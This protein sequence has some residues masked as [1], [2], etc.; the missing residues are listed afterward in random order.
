MGAQ[1]TPQARKTQRCEKV[2]SG[3]FPVQCPFFFFL[4]LFAK[5]ELSGPA[6]MAVRAGS[7]YGFWDN[8]AFISPAWQEQSAAPSRLSGM[9]GSLQDLAQRS[10]ME[11][12][13]ENKNKLNH[14][15]FS[16]SRHSPLLVT[17]RRVISACK[18]RCLD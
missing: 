8:Y 7:D 16:R 2:L 1:K 10:L 6:W 11:A 18:Q 15:S 3:F 17:A 13:K 12:V 5:T 4:L 9:A 14:F